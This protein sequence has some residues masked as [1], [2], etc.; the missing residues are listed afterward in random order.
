MNDKEFSEL[1][2]RATIVP[3]QARWPAAEYVHWQRLHAVANEARERVSKACM[4]MDE[5]DRNSDLSPEGKERQTKEA[6]VQSIANFE[7]SKSL[8]RA[9]EAVAYVMDQWKAKMGSVVKPPSTSLKRPCT[10]KSAT[11]SPP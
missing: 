8:A 5:I 10:P 11:A 3:Q 9:R 2:L 1:Q 7:A 4:L 6:A